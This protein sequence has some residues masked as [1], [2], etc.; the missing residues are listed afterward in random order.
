MSKIK[1]ANRSSSRIINQRAIIDKIFENKGISR[2][3]IAK[4]LG[5]SKPA[6]ASNVEHLINIGLVEERG[7]GASTKNGGRKP[8]L[9]HLK[10]DFRYIAA[11]DL[12]L[13]DCICAVSD[14]HYHLLGVQRTHIP[15]ATP[16]E[17]RKETICHILRNILKEKDIKENKLGMIIVSQPGI[18]GLEAENQ[19]SHAKHHGWTEIGLGKFLEDC[20]HVPVAIHNDVNMAAIGEMRFGGQTNIKDMIYI[21]CGIG[22]G[23]GIIING[24]LYTGTDQSAGEIGTYIWPGRE[25]LENSVAIEGLIKR[26]EDRIELNSQEPSLVFED[27]VSMAKDKNK[28]VCQVIFETGEDLGYAIYNSAALLGIHHVVLGGDY[29]QLGDSFVNGIRHTLQNRFFPTQIEESILG[30][31]AGVYGCFVSGINQ[32]IQKLVNE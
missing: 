29:L 24:Q 7:E 17:A 22:L 9:L 31:T 16:P 19:L 32:V 11:I 23:A 8:I 4:D 21:S 12:S 30:D 10:A 13:T 25:L 2:A 28:M 15:P 6:V 26:V 18:I 20:F 5:M 3:D 14:L 27:I 1:V